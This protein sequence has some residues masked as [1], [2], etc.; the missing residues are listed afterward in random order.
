M[1][2]L[3]KIK[4]AKYIEERGKE[5]EREGGRRREMTNHSTMEEFEFSAWWV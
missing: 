1:S 3:K 2:D 4:I 5:K